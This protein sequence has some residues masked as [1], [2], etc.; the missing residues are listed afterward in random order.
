MPGK[1]SP[2]LSL[3][4]FRKQIAAELRPHSPAL[5]FALRAAA[6]LAI[7]ESLSRFMSL[8]N[9]YWVPMTA[10]LVMKPD[11]GLSFTRALARLSGTLVG[12]V[13]ATVI[14][15]YLHPGAWVIAVLIVLFAWLC[16]NLLLVNYAVYTIC[17]TQY[18]VF[19][20]AMAGLP[21]KVV[22]AHRVFN[23]VLGGGLALL[24][25]VLWPQWET[26]AEGEAPADRE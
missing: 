14:V 18:V 10:L 17:V 1:L 24:L 13:I 4:G 15:T 5:R 2:D 20:L 7:A 12:A 9:G 21:A 16:Y 25:R 8:Q 23:T 6:T 26:R 3:P 11:L 22:V 19:L